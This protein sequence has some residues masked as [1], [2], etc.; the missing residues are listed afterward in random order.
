ME[1][2]THLVAESLVRHGFETTFDHRRLQWSK[3]FPCQDSCNLINAPGKPG[4]YALAEEVASFGGAAEFP[5]SLLERKDA[6]S[7][8][9]KRMLALFHL[10]EADDLGMAMGRLF[11][12]PGPQRERFATGKCFARYVV[13]EDQSQ[14]CAA[15]TALQRWMTSSAEVISTAPP[16]V[17]ML[18]AAS[19]AGIAET[20][21][22]SLTKLADR[23]PAGFV[24]GY[25]FSHTANTTSSRS[26]L[27]AASLQ[28]ANAP[29]SSNKQAQIGPPALIPSG[30]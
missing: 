3:W 12:A 16:T 23:S 2:L 9:G 29:E 28:S 18:L 30:F 21:S 14:R 15:Y 25:G 13:I 5:G 22:E 4:L 17:E 6:P 27:A 20:A 24:S 11:L 19:P 1:G 7:V 8:G 26:A 10:S